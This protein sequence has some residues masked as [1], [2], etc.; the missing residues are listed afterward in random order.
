MD[1]LGHVVGRSVIKPILGETQDSRTEV[2]SFIGLDG[3]YRRFIKNVSS[4]EIPLLNL[5]KSKECDDA[6]A[7]L[8]EL[9]ESYRCAH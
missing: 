9:E 6:F 2:R 7:Y 1:F 8:K 3:Y 5:I 4:I